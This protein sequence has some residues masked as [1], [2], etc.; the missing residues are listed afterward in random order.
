M[1]INSIKNS[2]NESFQV[3]VFF[4]F[5]KKPI[6]QNGIIQYLKYDIIYIFYNIVLI[7]IFAY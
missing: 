3:I 7:T 4:V 2:C 5:L 1:N 6:L